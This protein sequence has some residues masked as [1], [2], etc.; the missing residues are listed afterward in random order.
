M[1]GVVGHFFFSTPPTP[2]GCRASLRIGIGV[3]ELSGPG[4]PSAT[5]GPGNRDRVVLLVDTLCK[6]LEAAGQQL[7][8]TENGVHAIVD[9]EVMILRLGETKDKTEHQPTK[10]ELRAK[11]D[12]EEQRRKWPTMYSSATQHWRTWDYFPSGRLSPHSHATRSKLAGGAQTYD[13]G[14]YKSERS[15]LSN[16]ARFTLSRNPLRPRFLRYTWKSRL[17][18]L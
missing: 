7:K 14:Q 5:V 18:R 17:S 12:W 2:A 9:G 1:H 13:L 16:L 10:S 8:A 15:P 11:A 4:V 6:A 3:R